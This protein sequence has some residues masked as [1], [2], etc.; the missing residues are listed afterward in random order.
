MSQV[1]SLLLSKESAVTET[2]CYPASSSIVLG[3]VQPDYTI[4]HDQG[5]LDVTLVPSEAVRAIARVMAFGLA[6]GYK[7]DS[8]K[9]V[10]AHRYRAAMYRHLLDYLDDPEHIDEESGLPTIE[11]ILC[12]AAFL[13]VLDN[14]IV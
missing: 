5:K 9:T 6:K 13:S 4:K 3:T 14:G 7:R 12:N 8:W 11:H 10:E 2:R 1:K